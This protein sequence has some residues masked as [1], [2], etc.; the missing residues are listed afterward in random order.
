VGPDDHP[1]VTGIVT[2]ADDT[3]DFWTI[4]LDKDNGS[5]LWERTLPGAVANFS[6]AGWVAIAPGGDVM[7]ANRTWAGADS[8]DVVVFRFAAAD[9]ATIWQTQYNGPAQ[10][11]DD[12]RDLILDAAGD[13]Y[14]AGV[15]NSDFMVLKFSGATGD[16]VWTAAH[17]GPPG[18]YDLA[19]C[20]ALGPGG[21]V[22][23]GGF[24]TGVI[25]GWDA[26]TVGFDAATGARLWVLDFDRE[27][28]SDEVFDL[29]VSSQGDLYVAGYSYCA[30]TSMDMLTLRYWIDTASGVPVATFTPVELTAFP[31]PF[32]PRVQ[33]SFE[34]PEA[35]PVLLQ[36]F[37]LRGRAV[38]TLHEGA[39]GAGR[40]VVGWD[41]NDRT[42]TPVAAGIYVVRLTGD[43]LAAVRKVVLAK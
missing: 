35:G 42:G 6:R 22:I 21:E 16:T 37:D 33:L 34:L 23:A 38:T 28:Q 9:G 3:A 5:F 36:V 43:G 13:A 8:Y 17:D 20:L 32:N 4:K 15:S 10:N 39:L 40:H 14:V 27:G 24:S 2:N 18:W 41:G 12:P 7:M 19:S 26:T 11:A 31:N 25:T 1:V 30:A 29:G